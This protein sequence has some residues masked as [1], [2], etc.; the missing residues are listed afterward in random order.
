MIF[1]FDAFS[2]GSSFAAGT[3]A[4]FSSARET[5]AVIEGTGCSDRLNIGRISPSSDPSAIFFLR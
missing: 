5:P 3:S 4:G 2:I 1:T